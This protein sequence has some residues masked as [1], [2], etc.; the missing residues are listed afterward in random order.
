MTLENSK[1]ILSKLNS[2]KDNIDYSN[3]SEIIP[4]KPSFVK[5]SLI[6]P[7]NTY[8]YNNYSNNLSKKD[9]N[10]INTETVFQNFNYSPHTSSNNKT[11]S[12]NNV[13]NSINSNEDMSF[14]EGNDSLFNLNFLKTNQIKNSLFNNSNKLISQAFYNESNNNSNL[15]IETKPSLS[16]TNSNNNLKVTSKF[17]KKKAFNK[18]KI[19]H[20]EYRNKNN[21]KLKHKRKYKPDD[22]RKK[23][24]ARFHKSIKNII[25]E[26]LRKAGS[27]HLFSFL[28]QIFISSIARE[29]NHQV[30]NLTYR[31]ILQKDF[32]NE[33]DENKYKNKK[34][35]FSKYKNNLKVL[36]YLDN[37]PEICKNSG[38]DL[39]SKM[40][41]SD[42]LEEYFKSEEFQKAINK[43]R[44]E[45]EEEDYINE[46]INKA[47]N[48]VKFFSEIPFKLKQ[49]IYNKNS[50][51]K[52]I[53]DNKNIE[54]K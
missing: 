15:V 8:Y 30:L 33:I 27:K 40:K 3:K 32:V 25:N 38:F 46:Y 35:D 41:Y 12:I 53:D 28:P 9:I 13:S 5:H 29:T 16:L 22:I 43:L 52:E 45:N 49:S 42:L 54:Q 23:I 39:I 1:N 51:F 6:Y 47:K 11:N 2:I 50:I 18:F 36:E 31:E 4:I 20:I 17:K 26:N 44:E 34:V 14:K 10:R 7:P 24:K 37:N 19:S 21:Y 48:Y